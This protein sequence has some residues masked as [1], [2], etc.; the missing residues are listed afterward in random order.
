MQ[1][2]ET[3]LMGRTQ[4]GVRGKGTSL[5]CNS[6]G[7]SVMLLKVLA[8]MQLCEG[9]SYSMVGGSSRSTML[10]GTQQDRGMKGASSTN[11]YKFTFLGGKHCSSASC[12]SID[13]SPSKG[14]PLAAYQAYPTQHGCS[15]LSSM[16]KTPSR[17]STRVP[18][19]AWYR[20][21]M[22]HNRGTP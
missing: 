11:Q 7:V 17:I 10:A 4:A 9:Y 12:S 19:T 22:Q 3:I 5:V 21:P 1:G 18:H 13:V 16:T 14:L 20:Y 8:A 15:S 2:P 6:W